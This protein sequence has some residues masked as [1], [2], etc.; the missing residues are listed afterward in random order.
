MSIGKQ[1][2]GSWWTELP[3][4]A[5]PAMRT[6][7]L[8]GIALSIAD[9]VLWVVPFTAAAWAIAGL[10]S[11]EWNGGKSCWACVA[12][13][14]SF[15]LRLWLLPR[16]LHSGFLAGF[17]S[18]AALR[19]RVLNHLR[20]LSLETASQVAAGGLADLLTNRFRWLEEHAAYGVGRQVAQATLTCLIVG[21]LAFISPW[22]L[23]GVALVTGFALLAYRF[24]DRAFK[25]LARVQGDK[26]AAT[27]GNLIEFAVGL[28]VLRTL[29]GVDGRHSDYRC[30][31]AA[32][33]DFYRGTIW[34]LSPLVSSLRI[35]LDVCLL[36]LLSLTVALYAAG[37]LG[38]PDFIVAMVSLLLVQ[39]PV[40]G[41]IA[42]GFRLRMADDAYRRAATILALPPMAEGRNPP[43]TGTDIE[44]ENVRYGYDA[45]RPLFDNLTLS[46]PA[47]K[48]TAIVGPSGAGKSTLLKLIARATDV[49]GG[50]VRVGGGDV[51]DVALDEHLDRVSLL[52][53][54]PFLFSGTIIE[55]LRMAHATASDAECLDAARAAHCDFIER[56]P[57]GFNSVVAYNGG[58][59]SGGERLRLAIARAV[60]KNAPI[61]LLDEPTSALDLE[62]EYHVRQA[63]KAL[64][65]GRTVV[66]VAHRL[67]SIREADYLVV[68][69]KG[70]VIDDGTEGDLY[71]R[72]P[73]YR[74]L[75]DAQ[76][77]TA[78]WQ[79]RQTSPNQ[80]RS[81]SQ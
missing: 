76:L 19:L 61:L 10:S 73:L 36:A 51:R 46:I 64:C 27:G 60:L 55:N 16:A 15:V 54:E 7:Y 34:R 35:V 42:E 50:V 80:A 72:C 3:R 58:T 49:Q 1:G 17:G 44:F 20:S 69:E 12:V 78:R 40:E 22:L 57:S 43:V 11:G 32:L 2:L 47:G 13:V 6:K 53:Q 77:A 48:V 25:R 9:A 66:L 31:V 18:V 23:L 28:P 45:N 65:R 81:V 29:D 62:S 75:W 59:L 41:M 70:R 74:E 39:M 63:L 33:Y 24:I 71:G 79:L 38:M 8:A 21:I 4:L 56:L 5:H 68:M 37:S 30:H 26:L 52:A 14:L 67:S